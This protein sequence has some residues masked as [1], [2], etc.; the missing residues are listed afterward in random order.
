MTSFICCLEHFAKYKIAG[1]TLL[2][3]DRVKSHL[4]VLLKLEKNMVFVFPATLPM[5]CNPW[6]LSKVSKLDWGSRGV[7]FFGYSVR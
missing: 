2:I 7:K 4:E 5:S 6:L 3:F 1:S